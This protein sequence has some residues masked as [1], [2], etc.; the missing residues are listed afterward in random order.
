MAVWSVLGEAIARAA[1]DAAEIATTHMVP[2]I[3]PVGFA[4]N[5]TTA[6]PIEHLIVVVGENLSFD[7]LFGTY[8]PRSGGGVRSLLT[9]GIV[10]RMAVRVRISLRRRSVGRKFAKHMK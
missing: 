3:R 1:S 6:T 9:A 10:I 2:F 7:N 5:T 8:Q 4:R